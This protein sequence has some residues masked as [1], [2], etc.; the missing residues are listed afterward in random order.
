MGLEIMKKAVFLD[1][2]GIMNVEKNF[3]KS[4]DEFEFIDGVFE[5]I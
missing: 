1:R 3:V 2:D 5:N 4:W